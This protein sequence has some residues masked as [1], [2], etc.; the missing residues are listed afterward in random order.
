MLVLDALGR[1]PSAFLKTLEGSLFFHWFGSFGFLWALLGT[2]PGALLGGRWLPAGSLRSPWCSCGRPQCSSRALR[3]LCV[4]FGRSWNC[5]DSV[6][7]KNEK[8]IV[9]TL[10]CFGYTFPPWCIRPPWG[11]WGAFLVFIGPVRGPCAVLRGHQGSLGI[12]RGA[13]CLFWTPLE[14]VLIF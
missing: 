13:L 7:Q 8:Q 11:P 1:V 9:F 14:A 3:G 2:P 12:F 5:A 6:F 4:C 10:F